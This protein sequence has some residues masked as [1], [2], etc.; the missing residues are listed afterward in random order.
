MSSVPS[1]HSFLTASR[2]TLHNEHRNSTLLLNGFNMQIMYK[3]WMECTHDKHNKIPHFFVTTEPNQMGFS[4][5][6]RWLVTLLLSQ[7]I[8]R[9][10]HNFWKLVMLKV[11]DC[12][13]FC[14]FF[15]GTIGT[16]ED[17]KIC[18]FHRTRSMHAQWGVL[19]VW[20]VKEKWL[21]KT[22]A[23]ISSRRMEEK[24]QINISS[25]VNY[26]L[27]PGWKILK[28]TQNDTKLF[29]FTGTLWN[30]KL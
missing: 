13:F 4:P 2:L 28:N 19:P 25:R 14:F 11:R 20:D 16:V 3:S 15:V 24:K 1:I 8:M 10:I 21:G 29:L 6:C 9:L 30:V 26:F 7:S 27:L 18:K 5:R 12:N 17:E 23:R 22:R